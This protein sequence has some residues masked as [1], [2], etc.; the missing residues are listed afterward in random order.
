[1]PLIIKPEQNS[2][3]LLIHQSSTPE[4][5][6]T[7][8]LPEAIGD[9]DH[10]FLGNAP[11]AGMEPH[12]EVYSENDCSFDWTLKGT[13]RF[14]VHAQAKEDYLDVIMKLT[15]LSERSW[16]A[17][18]AFNCLSPTCEVKSG[19]GAYGIAD[20]DGNRTHILT[21]EG[22]RTLTNMERIHSD[23]PTIQLWYTHL[24]QPTAQFV[25]N[26]KATSPVVA[27]GAI[28]VESV[29]RK[30]T[31]AV[32]SPTPLF[33]F[34]NLEFACIHCCPGFGSLEPS[35][36]GTASNRVYFGSN[37]NLGTLTSKIEAYQANFNLNE[38]Y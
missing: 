23:R 16:P 37:Y 14:Q 9:A 36:T 17:T 15:N 32:A 24:E 11:G 19:G 5:V 13:L 25:E 18:F 21:N 20:F 35:M 22:W 29:D 34:S 6:L 27:K 4:N 10:P 28:A 26:F 1:M 33:L 31:V 8:T 12:W 7:F 30:T 3:H 38:Y 2:Q